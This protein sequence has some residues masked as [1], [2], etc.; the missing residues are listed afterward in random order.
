MF[1]A[2]PPSTLVGENPSKE[3]GST[4]LGKHIQNK[5]F[6]YHSSLF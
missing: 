3:L 2:S 1:Y 5:T 4:P 6:E